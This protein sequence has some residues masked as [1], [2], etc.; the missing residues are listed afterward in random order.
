VTRI[1]FPGGVTVVKFHFNN[2]KLREKNCLTKNVGLVENMKFLNPRGPRPLHLSSD[3]RDAGK[4]W[5]AS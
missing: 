5:L 3:A 2:S 4:W 1:I